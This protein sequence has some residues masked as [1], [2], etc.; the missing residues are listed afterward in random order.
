MGDGSHAYHVNK[1]T[2]S[3]IYFKCVM[4]DKLKCSGRAIYRFGGGFR[5]TKAHNHPPDPDYVGERHFREN[6][7]Q[8][9]DGARFVSF[10]DVL[11]DFRRNRN[12]SRRVRC[13]MTLRRLRGAMYR[14][15]MSSFPET[16]MTLRELT[17]R[18]LDP[19]YRRKIASTIDGHD[20]LYSGSCTAQDG[21][22][23]ILFLSERMKHFLGDVKI[24]QSDGTFKARPLHP[25]SSQI[26]VLVTP[27]RDA[28]VPIGW[29][30]MERRTVAAYTAIFSLL[31]Q[32]CPNFNPELI[33]SDWEYP[34]QKAW[35]DAFP[36]AQLQGCLWHMCRAFIKKA[37][38]LRIFR[39]KKHFPTL[40][41]YIR[42]ACAITLLPPRYFLVG[43]GVLRDDARR[44]NLVL[45]FLL[46]NFFQYVEDKWIL[47]NNRR[48]WMRLFKAVHRTNNLCE[49]HNKMLRKAIGAYRPNVWAFIDTLAKLE[50]NT[51]LDIEHMRAGGYA[52]RAR[53][54]KTVWT[55]E[56]LLALSRDL[57]MDVFR[58]RNEAVRSFVNQAS[59]VFR[60]A[61]HMQLLNEIG[62][63]RPNQ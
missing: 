52:R 62:R 16:P 22:H 21:S 31:K 15:R 35:R 42:K 49:S 61:F 46:V 26:F 3:S 51:T 43:L 63:E 39:F 55:D 28:V 20:N 23:H 5:H 19:E 40:V 14:R 37:H 18:L 8:H 27:W 36:N 41:D 34:Q 47:N 58:D 6:I 4:Y 24:I 57:E 54:W 38:K 25:Y 17:Q 53:T 29:F 1:E 13:R 12:Y 45:A 30:L 33:I 32:V 11:N 9:I 60:N 7:L 2:A 56:Q 59:T 44:E 50:H 10:E 48:Q